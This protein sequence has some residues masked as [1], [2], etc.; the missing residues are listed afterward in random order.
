MTNTCKK[1]LAKKKGLFGLTV[2]KIL[3]HNHLAI[4]LW[5]CGGKAEHYKGEGRVDQSCSLPGGRSRKGQGTSSLP[6]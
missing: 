2:V 5:A 1:Q 4:T 6:R 3:I